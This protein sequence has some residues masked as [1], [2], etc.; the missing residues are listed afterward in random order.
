M[1]ALLRLP[2]I[3]S[4]LRLSTSKIIQSCLLNS[5]AYFPVEVFL[6]LLPPAKPPT[7]APAP[8]A[9]N[10][11]AAPPAIVPRPFFIDVSVFSSSTSLKF[12]TSENGYSNS[13]LLLKNPGLLI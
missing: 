13:S 5:I 10:P 9:I 4:S 2:I 3:V 7:T 6:I 1:T 11:P 12:V 8:P